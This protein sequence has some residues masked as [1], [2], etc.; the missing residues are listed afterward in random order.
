MDRPVM[1]SRWLGVFVLAVGSIAC[2]S[3]SADIEISDAP[4]APDAIG[5]PELTRLDVTT[6][7]Y[8]R[9]R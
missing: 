8:E 6:L 3:P 5:L 1:S 4:R 7:S 9:I 2:G